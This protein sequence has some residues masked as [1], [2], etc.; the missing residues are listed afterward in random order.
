MRHHTNLFVCASLWRDRDCIAHLITYSGAL[1]CFSLLQN[2]KECTC[3]VLLLFAPVSFTWTNFRAVHLRRWRASVIPRGNALTWRNCYGSL[4]LRGSAGSLAHRRLRGRPSRISVR[5]GIKNPE[6]SAPNLNCKFLYL[7]HFFFLN[8][9][10]NKNR[11]KITTRYPVSRTT[12]FIG[13]IP[14]PIL[15]EESRLKTRKIP[16]ATPLVTASL[17]TNQIVSIGD[18]DLASISSSISGSRADTLPPFPLFGLWWIP[19]NRIRK[20]NLKKG[21]QPIFGTPVMMKND[22]VTSCLCVCAQ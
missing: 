4:R 18:V 17:F 5:I 7:F 11:P 10:Y 19:V 15:Q 13:P 16:F 8:S 22:K 6:K 3:L 12:S 9:I 1:L 21:E 2:P 14:S 20:F